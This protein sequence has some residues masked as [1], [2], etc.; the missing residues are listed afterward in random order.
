MRTIVLTQDQY[1]FLD[2]ILKQQT[3]WFELNS[4]EKQQVLLIKKLL[5]KFPNK[6]STENDLL[7][8]ASR[9]FQVAEQSPVTGSWTTITKSNSSFIYLSSIIDQLKEVNEKLNSIKKKLANRVK[10]REIKFDSGKSEA[11]TALTLFLQEFKKF[12]HAD[13]VKIF[14]AI[15]A[16]NFIDAC[17]DFIK[18]YWAID[19]HLHDFAEQCSNDNN[20]IVLGGDQKMLAILQVFEYSNPK[21]DW[22]L[23]YQFLT[24]VNQTLFM[25]SRFAGVLGD[26]SGSVYA[27][28][29]GAF[30]NCYS[31]K[32]DRQKLF[33]SDLNQ[34][35]LKEVD[36]T[37]FQKKEY[38]EAWLKVVSYL[39]RQFPNLLAAAQ[40]PGKIDQSSTLYKA[41]ATIMCFILPENQ[42]FIC[43]NFELVQE[44]LLNDNVSQENINLFIVISKNYIFRNILKDLQ[45]MMHQLSLIELDKHQKMVFED[46]IDQIKKLIENSKDLEGDI[47]SGATIYSTIELTLQKYTVT[48]S[49]IKKIFDESATDIK[50]DISLLI[51]TIDT[52]KNKDIEV[53]RKVKNDFKLDEKSVDPLWQSIQQPD[54][55]RQLLHPILGTLITALKFEKIKSKKLKKALSNAEATYRDTKMEGIAS[56]KSDIIAC[57]EMIE[58]IIDIYAAVGKKVNKHEFVKNI[59]SKSAMN[60]LAEIT[61]EKFKNAWGYHNRKDLLKRII[62]QFE[63]GTINKNIYSEADKILKNEKSSLNEINEII[64]ALYETETEKKVSVANKERLIKYMDENTQ[65]ILDEM[66][67]KWSPQWLNPIQTLPELQNLSAK[68]F[69]I[70]QSIVDGLNSNSQSDKILEKFGKF[71]ILASL[72]EKKVSKPAIACDKYQDLIIQIYLSLAASFGQLVNKE[73]RED[74]DLVDTIKNNIKN[75]TLSEI[76]NLFVTMKNQILETAK[77]KKRDYMAK[78][79]DLSHLPQKLP[80]NQT[81]NQANQP[82]KSHNFSYLNPSQN[83]TETNVYLRKVASRGQNSGSEANK[84]YLVQLQ[85]LQQQI[86]NETKILTCQFHV[87]NFYQ[88]IN[89]GNN[90]LLQSCASSDLPQFQK[91]L[92]KPDRE[93]DVNSDRMRN[94]KEW[95]D[96]RINELS[97]PKVANNHEL[98]SQYTN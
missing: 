45:V 47:R 24:F 59:F 41:Y 61:G 36:Q 50:I 87:R 93:V 79:P 51:S 37:L 42:K 28:M 16:K 49:R 38:L 56:D 39:V 86:F 33:Y 98:N 64:I 20:K 2:N 4:E 15:N 46:G 62:N 9:L 26:P 68:I 22:E 75:N 52:V 44:F 76:E 34:T 55:K 71:K 92:A 14:A 88:N 66:S 40:N 23:V 72:A 80:Q 12:F 83:S 60:I 96:S 78:I 11:D 13:V 58:A 90:P 29:M 85:N 91:F 63:N 54:N 19:Y 8:R 70:F 82:R 31:E 84:I 32:S 7:T 25:E 73:N 95:L 48:E 10:N 27:Y 74:T 30:Q 81:N 1:N 43:D 69:Q 65:A 5:L 97:N 18:I 21:Q 6:S 94:F 89:N 57:K 67:G 77:P 53:L 35:T 17:C 3:P